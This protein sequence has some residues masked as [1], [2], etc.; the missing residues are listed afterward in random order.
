[1]FQ[2]DLQQN[3][4]YEYLVLDFLQSKKLPAFLNPATDDLQQLQ[5]YDIAIGYEDDIWDLIDVKCDHQAYES[6]NLFIE[7]ASLDH[8]SASTFIYCVLRPDGLYFSWLPVVALKNAYD[9]KNEARRGDGSTYQQ[10]TYKHVQGGD[11]AT[12]E[13]IL[14]PTQQALKMQQSFSEW[15]QQLRHTR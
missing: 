6:G 3:K 4:L 2:S 11:Q 8:T 15:A 5:A 7:K 12:N 10:Y 1:M 9:A 14:L 13:G